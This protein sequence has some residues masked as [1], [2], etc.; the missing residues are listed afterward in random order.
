MWPTAA[1]EKENG[2]VHIRIN[3]IGIIKLLCVFYR[4]SGLH[5]IPTGTG[6]RSL[7]YFSDSLW[8]FLEW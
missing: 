4:S 6:P 7:Q 8:F 1:I 3:H 2:L 5:L